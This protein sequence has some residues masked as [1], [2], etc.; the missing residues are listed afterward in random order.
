M[1]RLYYYINAEYAALL[2]IVTPNYTNGK[3]HSSKQ[4]PFIPAP[5]VPTP[6]PQ[7]PP[8]RHLHRIIP[9]PNH[10]Q[11]LLE[12]LV[13]VARRPGFGLLH[14][15]RTE[16][17]VGAFATT[18]DVCWQRRAAPTGVVV[19]GNTLRVKGLRS[20][21]ACLGGQGALEL[22]DLAGRAVDLAGAVVGVVEGDYVAEVVWA[23]CV[24]VGVVLA[25]K[26]FYS[27]I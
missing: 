20:K 24:A 5:A 10:P 16:G 12:Q 15:A 18:G 23:V 8:H 3:Y 27:Y 2:L 1:C 19:V 6:P 7:E 13:Q 21:P 11:S 4:I 9:C 22:E 17:G 25:W 14:H 26:A